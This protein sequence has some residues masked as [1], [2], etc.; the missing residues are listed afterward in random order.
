MGTV[1]AFR[2]IIK[3]R[4]TECDVKGPNDL[5]LCLMIEYSASDALITINKFT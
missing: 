3:T 4:Q 1:F 5:A 2:R